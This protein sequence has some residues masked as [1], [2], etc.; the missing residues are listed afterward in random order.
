MILRLLI[1]L[2][3]VQLLAGCAGGP[4]RAT[5]QAQ[6]GLQAR[7]SAFLQALS[8]KDA[9]QV[10]GYFAEDA[11]LQI[12]NLPPFNG[13]QAIAGFYG[14]VFRFLS[15]STSTPQRLEVAG[16][17]ELAYGSGAVTNVFEGPQGRQEFS[18]K[19]LLVWRKQQGDWQVVA[20][21]LSNDR[22][23]AR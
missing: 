9:Q 20:Y 23:E 15:S 22:A 19:Y 21:S 6:S 12:P 13:R 17:A 3:L 18:G 1:A 10:A 8:S 4:A 2:V 14:N 16:N 5:Q 7:Q 11:V